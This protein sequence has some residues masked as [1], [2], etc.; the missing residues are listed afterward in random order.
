MTGLGHA[1]KNSGGAYRVRFTPKERTSSGHAG[2]AAWGHERKSPLYSITSSPSA[3]TG[4]DDHS[5]NPACR[6]PS[7][8]RANLIPLTRDAM[9]IHAGIKSMIRMMATVEPTFSRSSPMPFLHVQTSPFFAT[10]SMPPI[11]FTRSS[12]SG[13]WQTMSLGMEGLEVFAPGR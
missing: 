7:A 5:G 4:C 8:Y 10:N 9:I 1:R 12:P 2:S 3:N 13:T 6:N 11:C